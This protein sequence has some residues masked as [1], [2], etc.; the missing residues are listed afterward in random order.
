MKVI[1]VRNVNHAYHHGIAA[2]YDILDKPGCTLPS[3]VGMVYRFPTAVATVY[4]KPMERVLFNVKRDANPFFHFFEALWMLAGRNDVSWITQFNSKFGTYS[5]DGDTFNAAYG[6]R[7]RNYFQYDQL[8]TVIGL[9]RKDPWNRRV[10]LG[11]WNPHRDLVDGHSKDLP[12]NLNVK[13]LCHLRDGHLYLDM[14]VYNRSNDIIWGA[15][16]ANAVHMS[17]LHEYVASGA[18]M[19]VGTYTQIS[20][21]WHAYCEQFAKS[22]EPSKFYAA[23]EDVVGISE[24]DDLYGK[25]A[26]RPMPLVDD[27]SVFDTELEHAMEGTRFQNNANTMLH[28]LFWPMMDAYRFYKEKQHESAIKALLTEPLQGNDWA[29]ACVRWLDRRGRK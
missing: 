20:S 22:A 12:C 7:W 13:F 28:N 24:H 4:Q 5:D 8:T 6:Y 17:V 29:E 2:I 27:I 14:H 15:Y 10:V 9:L 23:P 19:A 18:G 25:H 11:M 26:V 16:G 3:R 1:D 21:D